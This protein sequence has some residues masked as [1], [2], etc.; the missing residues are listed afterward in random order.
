MDQAIETN[1]A[2]FAVFAGG[3]I[4]HSRW[5]VSRLHRNLTKLANVFEA[6]TVY[7]FPA[8]FESLLGPLSIGRPLYRLSEFRR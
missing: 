8:Q 6:L 5:I 3:I 1:I 7:F 4:P 2:L